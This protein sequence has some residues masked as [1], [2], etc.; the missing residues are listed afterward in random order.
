MEMGLVRPTPSWWLTVCGQVA[1]A[2]EAALGRKQFPF[3][4]EN[5]WFTLL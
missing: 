2:R 4:A 5:K 3:T 1:L